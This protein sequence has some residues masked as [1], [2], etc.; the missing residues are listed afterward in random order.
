MM[1]FLTARS[2]FTQLRI[3]GGINRVQL[4]LKWK[5][6]Y[7]DVSPSDL[8]LCVI[9]YNML[10]EEYISFKDNHKENGLSNET[11]V[12]TK[13]TNITFCSKIC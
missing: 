7:K 12:L 13:S 11:E 9:T 1:R 8:N 5:K 4:I 6:C 2:R 10:L 3:I